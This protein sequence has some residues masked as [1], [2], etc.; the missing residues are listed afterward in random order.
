MKIGEVSYYV[1]KHAKGIMETFTE[2]QWDVLGERVQCN[3]DREDLPF[4]I[5]EAESH[6]PEGA[7]LFGIEDENFTIWLFTVKDKNEIIDILE[8]L[9]R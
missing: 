6:A 7:S 3:A 2:E 5:E 9:V 1:L 4:D 8:E